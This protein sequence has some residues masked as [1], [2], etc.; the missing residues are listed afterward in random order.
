M[1]YKLRSSKELFSNVQSRW[2][3]PFGL[4]L[5]LLIILILLFPSTAI[6]SDP[7]KIDLKHRLLPPGGE[8]PLG[9]DSLGR[10]L[11][12]RTIIGGRI[13]VTS[14]F[15]ATSLGAFIG[16][17]V[18]LISLRA[19]SLVKE[20]LMIITDSWLAFP[21]LLLI[22]VL[23]LILGNSILGVILSIA[24]SVWPWWTRFVRNLLIVAY[25]QEYVIA[26]RTAGISGFQLFKSYILPQIMPPIGSAFFI[27]SARSVVLFG[28]I[29]FLGLGVQPPTPEWGAMIKDAIPLIPVAPWVIVGPAIGFMGTVT[30]FQWAAISMRNLANYRN[31]S[32]L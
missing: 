30:L 2:I 22:L 27:R 10:C 18:A 6:I 8:F 19:P 32:F 11:F 15:F 25:A 29:G 17:V 24:L 1:R 14:G 16:T 23:T 26:S 7:Y 12:S 9:T 28:G 5:L 4:L 3:Q 31:Y 20:P 21:D 13:T